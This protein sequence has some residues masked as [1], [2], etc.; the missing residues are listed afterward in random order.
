MGNRQVNAATDNDELRA[1]P[2]GIL[3]RL[4]A[5]FYDG[6]LLFSVIFVATALL[7]PF[8][9]G[10]AIEAGSFFLRAYLLTIA[11][12]FFAWFWTHGGQ[13]LGMRAWRLRLV[14]QDGGRLGWGNALLRYLCGLGLLVPLFAGLILQP[15]HE[16]RSAVVVLGVL[17]PLAAFLWIRRDSK[18][19]AWHDR[20]SGTR[21]IHEPKIAGHRNRT[22]GH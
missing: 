2:A 5:L 7:L 18:R 16:A 19:R 9:G 6:L 4:A 1:G 20:A 21:V 17:P 11:F 10:E 3:R 13:T 14:C 15:A 12:L 8:T 22:R